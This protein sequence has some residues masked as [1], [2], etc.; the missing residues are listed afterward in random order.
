M[1]RRKGDE[2]KGTKPKKEHR[3]KNGG[4]RMKKEDEEHEKMERV[5]ERG[6]EERNEAEQGT[7]E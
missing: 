1:G 3:N 2:R 6:R 4:Q 5:E 7:Q